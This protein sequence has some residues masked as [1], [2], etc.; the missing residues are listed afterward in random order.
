MH[1]CTAL[2]PCISPPL[3]L[4]SP[5]TPLQLPFSLRSVLQTSHKPVHKSRITRWCGTNSSPLPL[6]LPLNTCIV[7]RLLAHPSWLSLSL[8]PSCLSSESQAL[9]GFD[10]PPRELAAHSSGRR[11]RSRGC[12]CCW[13]AW[14]TGT[15]TAHTKHAARTAAYDSAAAG[16]PAGGAGR[17]HAPPG[18]SLQGEAPLCMARCDE[19]WRNASL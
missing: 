10:P 6:D 2:H 13:P 19:G 5:L 12:C 8:V 3:P 1:S 17:S 16:S 4:C 14:L 7:Q 11:S 9:Y 15:H 18:R